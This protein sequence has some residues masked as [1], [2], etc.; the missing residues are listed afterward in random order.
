VGA[1]AERNALLFSR[2]V[3]FRLAP[4]LEEDEANADSTASSDPPAATT[5]AATSAAA[6]AAPSRPPS[7]P[8][9]A[10]SLWL[11]LRLLPAATMRSRTILVCSSALIFRLCATSFLHSLFL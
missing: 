7:P 5:P 10:L 11:G 1:G 6:A 4:P 2:S 8:S 3:L 9:C